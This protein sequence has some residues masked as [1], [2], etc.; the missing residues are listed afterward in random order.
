MAELPEPPM[1]TLSA[2]YASYEA[3]QGDG[4]RDHLG[5]SLI[6]KSCARALWYD[7]RWATPARHT[8]R[9][10]RL[11]ET[12]QLEEA[13]LVRDLRATGATVLEVDPETGRQFRVEAH[14]GHF[15]GSLDA[16]A[17]GLLEAPKTWHVV[18]FKTHSAKSFAELVA[19]GVANAKPQHAAQMQIY[20]HLTGITRALYVAV[21]KDTTRCTSSAS[22][23]TQRRANACWRRRGGSSS[24]STRPSGSARIPPGSSAGSA[25]T[26]GSATA[27]TP[28]LSPAGPAC[29]R[30]PSKAAGTARA[31]TGCSTPPTSA[32]RAPGT[33]SSPISFPAR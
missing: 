14:G 21:C 27:R 7:F 22:R 29:I 10:L 15:G 20:M 17:L 33:C 26:T 8:G 18:E 16:V 25:T 5:A 1:P 13:R 3:R 24:P 23:P 32:A 12:G 19:K 4:F 31:T 30:R 9:I 6:G 28:R 11:F 2:I